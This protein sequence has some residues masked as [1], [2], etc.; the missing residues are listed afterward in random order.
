MNGLDRFSPSDRTVSVSGP[1]LP[2]ML[3][4]PTLVFS[5]LSG[6][7]NLNELFEYELE[8]RTPD[9]RNAIYG[10][11]A[12][13]DK[14][15]LEGT[16]VTIQIELDGSGVGL[17]GGA[18]A[19]KREITGIVTQVRGPYLAG[20]HI[21]Y[22]LTLQPWLWLATRRSDYKLYQNKNVVEI[23]DELLSHYIYPVDK[24]LD[25]R[26]Y[27][28]RVFQQQYGETDYAYFQRLTQE[29]GISWFI[30]HSNKR[31][32]LV[33]TD[34]NGV[35][36]PYA[37]A[38]Y[39][40]IRWQP[41]PDRIDEE[42]IHEF[43]IIDRLVSGEW[44][45][46]DYDF[47]KPRADLSISDADPRDTA[48]ST[49]GIY[50]Y[51]GDHSQPNTDSDPWAEGRLITGIR[52]QEIRQH[53][54]RGRGKGNLR[55]MVPGCTFHLTNFIEEKANREYL[56][57][58]TKLCIEEVGEN[59]GS[60]QQWHCEVEFDVQPSNEIFRP[61]RTQKKPRMLG[62]I[63]ARVVGPKGHPI[64]TN[65]YGC[66]KVQMPYDMY[67][68]N[69]ENSS[70]WVRVV[71]GWAGQRFGVMHLPRV[72]QEVLVIGVQ[73]DPD[74]LVAVGRVYNKMN[75]PPWVLP[76]MAALSGFTS[77]ELPAGEDNA[78]GR[79]NKILADDT[80]GQPQAQI[81]SDF[82]SSELA[83]GHIVAIPN[84][85]GRKEKRGEGFEL[86]TDAWGAM[87]AAMGMLLT[88]YERT[89]S[90]DYAMS[91][92]DM[93]EAL[94]QAEH[95]TE[96]LADAA[97]QANAQDGEQKAVAKAIARQH[98]ALKG[99]GPL[100]EFTAPHL[101]LTSPVGIAA[102]TPGL[103]HVQSG[104]HLA[105][106]TGEH[107]SVTASGGFFAS[108]R[109]AWRV[110]VYEAGMRLVAAAGDINIQALKDSINLLA[111]L[112]ITATAEKILIKAK[113]ELLLNG[114]GSYLKLTADGIENGTEGAW[115]VYAASKNLTGPSSLPVD[116]RPKQ[117]CLEC[118]LKAA[119]RNA[120]VVP[121]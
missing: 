38:A 47:S 33:L 50:E 40:T 36:S 66:I 107:V 79:Q 5:R 43:E 29:W 14:T 97:Q 101:A 96:Q 106:T 37:S 9:E 100:K 30:E 60:G 68:N 32:R 63:Q 11:A 105:I 103:T 21:A 72:G 18:G 110:F 81:G 104:T 49:L 90:G 48:H 54:L 87:R 117:V 16:E 108:V 73:G 8:L 67:G 41:S 121:R 70:F 1:A 51:P 17:R 76:Q 89:D 46:S 120:A 19:G 88:T 78:G 114:G 83:L 55:A 98:L 56:I 3:G 111:K 20:Q 109:K 44:R 25:V 82:Q 27:P 86:R 42:H 10:P 91:M 53:G 115:K 99:D 92:G 31:Q 6:T 15:A 62:P 69:D 4:R 12:D 59:T 95:Q 71:N 102:S 58:A 57:F 61:E 80:P 64:H 24:R 35:F 116:L 13:L 74:C 23:L 85:Q 75:L 65:E 45:T 39:Q 119:T 28:K 84:W 52:M 93:V 7:E 2:S 113:Q 34:S 112:E 94:Q 26:K 77:E 22:R 118:L